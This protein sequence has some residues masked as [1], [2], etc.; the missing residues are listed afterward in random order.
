MEAGISEAK[1]N[2][3]QAKATKLLAEAKGIPTGHQIAI[4]EAQI[5]AAKHRQDGLL[6]AL[7]LMQKQQATTAS[8]SA[9]ASNGKGNSNAN[10]NGRGQEA[11]G[12][13]PSDG[14][15]PGGA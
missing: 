1:I 4:I 6:K 2:E 13:Q 9:G 3:L 8:A 14:G 15:I 11:V 10:P 5:G 12:A 7:D